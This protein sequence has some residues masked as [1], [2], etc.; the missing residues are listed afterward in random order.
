[1]TTLQKMILH[2]VQ[3]IPT[4]HNNILLKALQNDPTIDL[5][6]WYARL[7][8]PQYS[9]KPELGHEVGAS[10]VYGHR[11]PNWHLIKTA[12]FNRRDKFFIVGWMN[13]TTQLLVPLFWM[14][15]R[16]YNMWFDL[17][18][19]K[20]SSWLKNLV[21]NLYYFLLKTSKAKVFAVGRNA[22][23]YFK[24]RGFSDERV[25][26]LPILVAVD[27]NTEEYRKHRAEIRTKYGVRDD[28][29]FIVTGSRLI[30]EKGFDL[31]I[32]A[33][34]KLDD[35]TRSKMKL[36]LIGKGP[37][38]PALIRQVSENKLDRSVYFEDWMDHQEF[39]VHFGAA[40]LAVH[41]ARFDAYGGITL[42]A[43]VAGIPVVASNQA[44]SA[45]DRIEQGVNGWLYDCGDTSQL[46][47]WLTVAF[48][49]RDLLKAMGLSARQ[50]AEQY[51]PNIGASLIVEN[52][53]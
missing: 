30:H 50:T 49:N 10:T 18:S 44:G 11:L 8:H 51:G 32:Q 48:Q 45:I 26:N 34:T 4:P 25:I 46:A 16:P 15:R 33:L 5:H 38:K 41:P 35:Y 40:D 42:S 7:T 28:E 9:F 43:M 12:V 17:P 20:S 52:V 47:H 2:F 37:E 19:E 29:L 36:L 13:P 3:D 53:L 23:L 27:K 14:L 31:L 1:M 22:I 39:M 21:R 24:N 6:I